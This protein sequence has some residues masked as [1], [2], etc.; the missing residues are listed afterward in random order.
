MNDPSFLAQ[1]DGVRKRAA[2]ERSIITKLDWRNGYLSC[3]L[4]KRREVER[5]QREALEPASSIRGVQGELI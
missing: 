2:R 5:E 3:E 1:L 4:R